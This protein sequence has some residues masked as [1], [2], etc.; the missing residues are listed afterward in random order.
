MRK[1]V[2]LVCCLVCYY[3]SYSQSSEGYSTIDYSPASYAAIAA[4]F[5]DAS[6]VGLGESSHGSKEM[7]VFKTEFIK[8]LM[9]HT[10]YKVLVMEDHFY[11][12]SQINKYLLTGE[13]DLQ[14]VYGKLMGVWQTAEFLDLL[15]WMRA[16]NINQASEGSKVYFYGAD[17]QR[18][19]AILHIKTYI[20]THS[21][22]L[23][24][25]EDNFMTLRKLNSRDFDIRKQPKSVQK[26]LEESVA[27]LE[28]SLQAIGQK[29][30]ELKETEEFNMMQQQLEVLKQYYENETANVLKWI[31]YRDK[32][33]AENINWI[34]KH[35]QRR[36]NKLII[37]AHNGHLNNVGLR[38]GR[39]LKKS[40]PDY[41]I[42]GQDFISGDISG[43]YTQQ[44]L[45]YSLQ[46]EPRLLANYFIDKPGN[47]FYINFKKPDFTKT[48]LKHYMRKHPLVHNEG[49][50]KGTLKIKA[51]KQFDAIIIHR[52]TSLKW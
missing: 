30:P 19:S 40:N 22:G 5:D 10:N 36:N 23:T 39:Y 49:A 1:L 47:T 7:T 37:W 24:I 18:A 15:Q 29:K 35:E 48:G 8:Y 20:D 17:M 12:C 16:Y 9:A 34:K 44:I 6:M 2:L 45:T 38:M 33:M 26:E 3:C 43:I 28:A 25:P 52:T 14:E 21:E 32:K 11:D 27:L 31:T 13:G 41:F 51:G 42:L 4:S 46:E 50:S